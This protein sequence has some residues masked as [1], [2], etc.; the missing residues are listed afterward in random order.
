MPDTLV[1]EPA[2]H[3][4]VP[5]R[6]PEPIPR[7]PGQR[8]RIPRRAAL[9]ALAALV[10]I[11]GAVAVAMFLRPVPVE[12]RTQPAGATIR[13]DGEPRG[14]SNLTLSL[15]RGSHQIEI[16]KD[17]FQSQKLSFEARRGNPGL[18]VV[19]QPAAVA[20][21][22]SEPSSRLQL[23]SDLAG[24]VQLDDQ[25]PVELQ[26]GGFSADPLPLGA[27]TLKIVSSNGQAALK[28][29]TVKDAPAT[30]TEPLQPGDLSIIAIA[31]A[32]G[33]AR[34]YSNR[35]YTTALINTEPKGKLGP[36]PLELNDL[37]DGAY[38]LKL[39]PGKNARAVNFTVGPVP[40]MRISVTSGQNLGDLLVMTGEDGV[41]VTVDGKKSKL[42]SH[43]E[44]SFSRL[45]VG[46]HII[47][48][49]KDGF[50]P[51]QKSVTI[52]KGTQTK[53]EFKLRPVV[54]VA[55]LTMQGMPA[56]ARVSLDDKPAGVISPDGSFSADHLLPGEHTVT[57]HAR[58]A[59][60]KSVKKT[61]SAGETVRLGPSDFPLE[62]T[63]GK[64]RVDVTPSN[65]RVRFRP[66][67]STSLQDFTPGQELEE[68][69][70]VFTAS[71]PKYDDAPPQTVQVRG[72]QT[73]PVVLRLKST[74]VKAPPPQPPTLKE[75]AQSAGLRVEDAWYVI[76]GGAPVLYPYTPAMGRF[77][78][79][80]FR[81]GGL[82]T[83]R[84]IRWVTNYVDAQNYVLFELDQNSLY[85]TEVVNGKGR[86]TQT[87]LRKKFST[88]K[89]RDLLYI[90]EV[91][92]SRDGITH[93]LQKDNN[94]E[95]IDSWKKADRDFSQGKFGFFLPE[96][97]DSMNVTNFSLTP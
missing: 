8:Q 60:P 27:H 3:I 79:T 65:A 4:P 24:N 29:E 23:A 21:L 11:V 33:Q 55:V 90:I 43:G 18:D 39:G 72:G 82:I 1:S 2:A 57:L 19:L 69:A 94:L 40:E 12:I 34:I 45:T 17:G 53:L 15:G 20:P 80:V 41:A 25:P 84:R 67:D 83:T 5:P 32:K 81:G 62:T 38:E 31:T 75:W 37:A 7:V 50:Q 22:P 35:G 97:K 47:G 54:S 44:L 51:D 59:K 13:V 16:L 63:L 92:I 48:V 95:R 66:V 9:L 58:N 74:A 56:G 87:N 6:Q 49:F 46:E 93:S 61:F 36:V 73:T 52:V 96:K 78:F 42:S 10:F 68:G 77:T 70:Y 89:G 91:A 26:E 30:L 28:F 86:E 71:A 76:T 85:R 14:L 88:G 64:V